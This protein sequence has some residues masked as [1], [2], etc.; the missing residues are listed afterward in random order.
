MVSVVQII[1][2][3]VLVISVAALIVP[4]VFRGMIKAFRP[5]SML[6]VGALIRVAVGL[7][8]LA[9]APGCRFPLGV[10][11][12]GV[13]TIAAGVVLPFLKGAAKDALF[14]WAVNMPSSALRG[15]A[16][17]GVVLGAFLAYVAG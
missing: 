3:T 15:F 13:V 11:I 10:Q 17:M 12:L 16:L 4:G 2:M 7:V 14:D 5:Q 6:Y 9:A 1:G 8:L